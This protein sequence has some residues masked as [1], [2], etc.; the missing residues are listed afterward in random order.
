MADS[1][2]RIAWHRARLKQNRE[3]LKALEVARFRAGH[4]KSGETDKTI[5]ELM[6]K[7]AESESCIAAHDRQ[8]RRPLGTDFG[9]LTKVSWSAWNS[10][11][12][13]QR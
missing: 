8:T 13:G 3:A 7:I 2:S 1:N 5:A 11:S 4:D 10:H 9:S 6:R 12:S